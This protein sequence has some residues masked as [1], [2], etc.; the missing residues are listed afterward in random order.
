MDKQAFQELTGHNL[1][2]YRTRAGL[3]QEQLAER[4]GIS[5]AYYAGLEQGAKSM[6]AAVLR[7]LA[8]TLRISADSLLY[9]KSSNIHLQNICTIL[10]DQPDLFLT[11]AEEVID[12]KSVV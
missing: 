6:S 8:E 1:R 9:E 10:K 7:S 11:A 12:R 4:A 5:A 3:T 2:R